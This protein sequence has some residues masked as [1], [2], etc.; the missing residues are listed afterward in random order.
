MYCFLVGAGR[1]I[2]ESLLR[3]MNAPTEL[4]TINFMRITM[5]FY[6]TKPLLKEDQKSKLFCWLW[7]ALGS[8]H[9]V[10]QNRTESAVNLTWTLM[11]VNIGAP[12]A[13]FD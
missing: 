6:V 2:S 13:P 9:R 4:V 10:R 12:P 7:T 8:H 5:D 3:A 11:P 1:L